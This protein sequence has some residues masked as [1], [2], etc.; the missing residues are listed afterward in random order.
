MPPVSDKQARAM[1]A[2]ASG[3]S[4][5]GI[6]VSVGKEFVGDGPPKKKTHRGRKP[7]GKP[8]AQHLSALQLAH[9]KGDTK[10]AHR[11]ALD[12]AKELTKHHKGM[13]EPDADEMGGPSDN[14]MDDRMT[15]ATPVKKAPDSRAALAK[16]AMRKKSVP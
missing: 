15:I 10:G 6:P 5:L 11:A 4:T 7:S 3:H 12:Y 2:A 1:H 14:D 9:G 16:L 8:G 13:S